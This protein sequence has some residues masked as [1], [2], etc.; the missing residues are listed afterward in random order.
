MQPSFHI[1]Q[2][3]AQRNNSQEADRGEASGVQGQR[4]RGGPAR[5]GRGKVIG[6]QEQGRP[7][8]VVVPEVPNGH[9]WI[10]DLNMELSL[11]GSSNFE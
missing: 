11:L 5:P 4:G 2:Q 6:A 10:L 8:Q 9:T 7:L 1:L 3:Q